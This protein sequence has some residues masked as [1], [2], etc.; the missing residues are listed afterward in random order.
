MK[1]IHHKSYLNA[2]IYEDQ[3][4]LYRSEYVLKDY[5]CGEFCGGRP[6]II[7]IFE[8]NITVIVVHPGHSTGCNM[9]TLE[10]KIKNTINLSPIF[11]DLHN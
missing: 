11:K 4:L 10:N 6:Y 5:F 7:A 9:N 2:T 3:V 8:N 1:Y